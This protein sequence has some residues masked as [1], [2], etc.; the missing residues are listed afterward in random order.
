MSAETTSTLSELLESSSRAIDT[1]SDI[2]YPAFV[3][4]ETA[5]LDVWEHGGI[6][7]ICTRWSCI[8]MPPNQ[9]TV[10]RFICEPIHLNFVTAKFKMLSLS[11]KINCKMPTRAL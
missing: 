3:R 5:V 7:C 11:V 9:T 4:W 6:Y 1:D 8:Y 10:L 2:D